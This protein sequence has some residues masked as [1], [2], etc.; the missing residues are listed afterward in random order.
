[1]MT[2]VVKTL[3]PVG[4]KK[5]AIIALGII[6]FGLMRQPG[7]GVQGSFQTGSAPQEDTSPAYALEVEPLGTGDCGRCH[8]DI[9]QMIKTNGGK[10]KIECR[11][12]H[13][14]FHVFRPGRGPYEEVLPKCETCHEAAIHGAELSG[15][16]GCHSR[17]HAPLDIPAERSLEQGCPICHVEAVKEIR[18]FVTQHSELYC[19]SCHHTRHRNVPECIACHQPHSEEMTQS[20]CLTC[21]PP[22]KVLEVVYPEGIPK[23]ACAGCHRRAYEILA[24]SGS[25]HTALSCA[26]CHRKHRGITRCVECHPEPHSAAMLQEFRVCGRCHGEA[27]SLIE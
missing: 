19:F 16:S 7:Y 26:R 14:Q 11:T 9:Y 20:D 8:S 23:E 13:V 10:H 12:C 2:P 5:G 17:A 1:M 25:K 18:T 27:H 4:F 6:A 3:R 22:H 15:C 21:H 24:Q